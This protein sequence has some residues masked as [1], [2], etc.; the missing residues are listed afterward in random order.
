VTHLFLLDTNVLSEPLRPVPNQ[1]VL[2]KIRTHQG[3]LATGTIVWHELLYGYSRL[4]DSRKRKAIEAYLFEVVQPSLVLFD[5][6]EK[7]AAWHARERVRLEQRGL[8]PTFADGQIAAI[9]KANECV[10]ITANTDDFAHYE[11]LEVINWEI[12]T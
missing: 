1:A 3:R 11:G 4:P 7:A 2:A 10:L 8:T 9:A 5:Y 6:D 12:S